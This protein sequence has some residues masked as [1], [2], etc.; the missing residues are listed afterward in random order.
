MPRFAVIGLGRFGR[1]LAQLLSRAGAEVI[2]IDSDAEI[3]QRVRDDVA[4]AV[5]MD[6]TDEEAL[7]AQGIDKVDCAVVGIGADFEANVLTVSTLKK[8]GVPRV[9]GRSGSGVREEI[10]KR[11][12]ADDV[13]FPEDESA[14]RWAN[15]LMMPHFQDFVELDE[16]HSLVQVPAPQ[17]FVR[18]TPRELELRRKHKLNLVAIRRPAS[19]GGQAADAAKRSQLIAVIDPDEPIERGDVLVL[20]GSNTSLARLPKD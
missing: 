3:V 17:A 6:S 5:R 20:I 9:V 8:I 18:K 16:D 2:A 12:G 19:V 1:K 4:L 7:L 14:G 10:L 15:H 13:V 11:V